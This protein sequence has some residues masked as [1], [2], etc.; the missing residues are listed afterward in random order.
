MSK[1]SVISKLTGVE[2]TTE[3]AQVTLTHSSVIKLHLERSD[4]DHFARS[5]NDLVITLHSGETIT[6][7]NFY[8]ADAQGLSQLVLEED[9]G[10]LWWVDDPAV[11][12]FESIASTDV[13][14]AAAGTESATGGAVWPW[15][16]GGVAAAGALPLP[17][18]V[19]AEAVVAVA[20]TAAMAAMAETLAPI[21]Q[22]PLR[23]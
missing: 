11:V 10:L 20:V 5:S 4:I 19:V 2:S 12:H 8:V 14:L 15:V 22:T 9:G 17:Q 7:K 18:V 13:L 6:I 16:L 3:G 1:I 23:R 21:Q